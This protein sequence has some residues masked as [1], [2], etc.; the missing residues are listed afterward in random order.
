M[1]AP[2]GRVI[3][4]VHKRLRP[5]KWGTVCVEIGFYAD[6]FWESRYNI[7]IKIWAH[8]YKILLVFEVH[9]VSEWNDLK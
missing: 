7:E 8:S 5:S 2:L 4:H 6:I 3:R 9:G 1:K